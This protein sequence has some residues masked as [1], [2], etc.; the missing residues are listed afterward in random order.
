MNLFEEYQRRM[1]EA[2]R[3]GDQEA[4]RSAYNDTIDDCR[5]G[6]ICRKEADELMELYV[7]ICYDNDWKL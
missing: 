6:C 3:A 4:L 2:G 5:R 7:D 1:L